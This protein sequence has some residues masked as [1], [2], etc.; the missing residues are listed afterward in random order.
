[1]GE[2]GAHDEVQVP[3]WDGLAVHALEMIE[4]IGAVAAL[5][6]AVGLLHFPVMNHHRTVGMAA[7]GELVL[8]RE[9]GSLKRREGIFEEGA[10]LHL[11]DLFGDFQ[12]SGAGVLGAYF[13]PCRSTVSRD[14]VQHFTAWRSSVSRMPVQPASRFLQAA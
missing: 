12:I 11:S 7:R 3:G 1:M 8:E 2:H 10:L 13:T 9:L 4:G 5:V 14:P 6:L